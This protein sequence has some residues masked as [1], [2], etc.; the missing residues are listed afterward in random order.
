MIALTAGQQ[1]VAPYREVSPHMSTEEFNGLLDEIATAIEKRL[2]ITEANDASAMAA[3]R[4]AHE[5]T[6]RAE[7]LAAER[8]EGLLAAAAFATV[9]AKQLRDEP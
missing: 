4:L 8:L 9:L 1:I 3:L 2:T 6:H 5:R 7:A